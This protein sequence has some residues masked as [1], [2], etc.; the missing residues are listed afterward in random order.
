MSA[1]GGAR[2]LLGQELPHISRQLV[3]AVYIRQIKRDCA[4]RGQGK[5]ATCGKLYKVSWTPG[6]SQQLALRSPE[7]EDV[8]TDQETRP[9]FASATGSG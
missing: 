3:T 5:A 2:E 7:K 1:I 9:V 8:R 6:S 4:A